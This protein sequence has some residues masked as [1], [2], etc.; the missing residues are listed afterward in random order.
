M[1]GIS[2]SLAMFL[3]KGIPEGL[4]IV[5][6]IHILTNTNVDRKKFLLLSAVYIVTTY[7]IRLLPITLGINTVLSFVVLVF[8]F[9]LSYHIGL[10][11]MTRSL[12]A[13][14]I[15]LVF[16]AVSEIAN[17]L[18]LTVLYGGEQANA[19]MASQD[20]MTQAIYTMPSTVFLAIITVAVYFV[21][22]AIKKKRKHV[23]GETGKKT[24]E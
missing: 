9:Q 10:P 22:R 6:G 5:W 21:A 1:N 20:K 8:C 13:A 18:F 16:T 7:L 17:V 4:L 23:D 14:V 24:G 11:K 12:A 15:L 2:V 3:M 19:L